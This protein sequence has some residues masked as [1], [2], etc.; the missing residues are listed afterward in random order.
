MTKARVLFA[1]TPAFALASLDALLAAGVRPLAVYTQPDR[2]AGRGRV[3]APGPVKA[4]AQ[5]EA[6][7]VRQPATLR[8]ADVQA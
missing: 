2:P 3:T 1:G 7:P 8:D 6:I 5:S 4:R